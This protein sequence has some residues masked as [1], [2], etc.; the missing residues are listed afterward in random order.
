MPGKWEG[1]EEE[2]KEE[3]RGG[4]KSKNIPSVD[5]CLRPMF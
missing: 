3:E 1:M 2:V 4:K 5:S